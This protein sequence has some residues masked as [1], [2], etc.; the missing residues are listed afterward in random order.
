MS[1][2]KISQF[3]ELTTPSAD[4]F[5]P[6]VDASSSTTKKIKLSN[7]PISALSQSKANSNTTDFQGVTETTKLLTGIPNSGFRNNTNL[8][9]IYIGSSVTSIGES[10]FENCVNLSDVTIADGT[11]SIGAKA[12][13]TCTGLTSMIIPNSVTSIG[14]SGFAVCRNM[15]N[16]KLSD[17]MTEIP[18]AAFSACFNLTGITI[19]DSVTGIGDSAFDTCE[20]ATTIIIGTGVTSIGNLAF[21]DCQGVT[22]I[23]CLAK[24]APTLG[25]D[26]FTNFVTL[27]INVPTDGIGYGDIYG[28][29]IVVKSL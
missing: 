18:N 4:D 25:T 22:T 2:K 11:T 1:D 16:I 29:L 20:D 23:N 10:A 15:T 17:N 24:N 9:S 3:T 5:L 26:A 8:N 19:P 27:T 6:V 14:N 7:L 28:S 13:N 21:N 12:F